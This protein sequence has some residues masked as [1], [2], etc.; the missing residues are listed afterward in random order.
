MN[1]EPKPPGRRSFQYRNWLSLSGGIIALGSVFSFILLFALDFFSHH[2]NPYMGILAYVVA[3]V[4]FILGSFLI[5]VG[6]WLHRRHT[7]R[8]EAGAAPYALTIDLSRRRDRRA[9]GGF[10]AGAVLFLLLSALGSYQTYHY[11]ESIQ[12][13]GQACHT[14]MK[15]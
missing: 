13:C 3:P 9:L 1:Q 15:P 10:I 2:G 7:R 5:F 6:A 11:S 12:F 8:A 4:F 14:P